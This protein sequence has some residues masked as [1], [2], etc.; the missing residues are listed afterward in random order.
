MAEYIKREALINSLLSHAFTDDVYGM[1]LTRGLEIAV[2]QAKR[3]PYRE[4]PDGDVVEVVRCKDCKWR[5][6][7]DDCTHEWWRDGIKIVEDNDFCSYGER[8]DED[9]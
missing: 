2:A 3:M 1:G 6:E 4:I 7:G 5:N 8:R 9:G